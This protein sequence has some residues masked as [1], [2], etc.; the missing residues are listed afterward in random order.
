LGDD[1]GDE[2]LS[3]AANF[4][5]TGVETEIEVVSEKT[6]QSV[7]I[8]SSPRQDPVNI[9]QPSSIETLTED[10]LANNE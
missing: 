8:L 3:D 10:V 9:R 1:L 4:P 5:D 7:V 2:D 6:K